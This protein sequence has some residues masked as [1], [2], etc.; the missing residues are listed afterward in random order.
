MERIAIYCQHMLG[1]FG[2]FSVALRSLLVKVIAQMNDLENKSS[3]MRERPFW[4]MMSSGRERS[5]LK[6][7]PHPFSSPGARQAQLQIFARQS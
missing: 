5:L 7:I 4:T 6:P 2:V 3:R 1:H